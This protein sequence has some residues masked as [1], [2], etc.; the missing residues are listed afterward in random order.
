MT[1]TPETDRNDTGANRP[2]AGTA[3]SRVEAWFVRDVLPLE[4]ALMQFLEHNWRNRS[5]IADLRQD[6]YERVCDAAQK[7][8]PVSAKAFVFRV[9]RNLLVDRVRQEQIV[10][11]EAVADLDALEVAMDTPGPERN[12]MARD[13]LRLLQAAMDR[14]P[15]R[16]REALVLGRVDGLTGRQIAA[17]MNVTEQAVSMHI[18]HGVRALANVL[19][20]DPTDIRRKA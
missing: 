19:Y 7:E 16:C 17:R 13:E 15:P 1:E 5:D 9:A 11:I 8:I 6:V 12:V 4:A 2:D 3:I 20:G 10:P 18:D 14:L